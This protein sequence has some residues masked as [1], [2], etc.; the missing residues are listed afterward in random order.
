MGAIGAGLGQNANVGDRAN[1]HAAVMVANAQQPI[2]Q[3]IPAQAQQLLP[4]A[5]IIAQQPNQQP[6]H[7]AQLNAQQ[8]NQQPEQNA[9]PQAQQLLPNAQPQAQQLMPNAQII[10]QQ[11]N[12][13]PE[14]NAQ[15]QALQLNQQQQ[16]QQIQ[17][18][19]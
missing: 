10:A 7:D 14:Q 9:Q 17:N 15:A 4:I 1:E 12:Q 16:Q 13:Q 5:Q 2:Q 8:L 18:P 11:P 3:Q 19:N 6:E